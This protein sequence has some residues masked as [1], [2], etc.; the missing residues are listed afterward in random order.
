MQLVEQGDLL[1]VDGLSCPVI[2]VSSNF[3]NRSGKAVVPDP[4]PRCGG[5]AAY[6]AE[7]YSR[8]GIRPV[9]TDAL[10][11]PGGKTLFKAH[12]HA[13]FRHHGY[14]RRGNVHLRLS[15]HITRHALSGFL[16]RGLGGPSFS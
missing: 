5:P 3:F 2:V 14:F 10:R 13:L 15:E 9:R 16:R 6:S 7:R 1:N 11:R 8:R 12:R 4:A